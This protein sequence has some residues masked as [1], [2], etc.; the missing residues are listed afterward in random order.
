MRIAFVGTE[1]IPYPAAFATIAEELGVRL[2]AKGHQVLVY[3]RSRYIGDRSEYRGIERV[4]LPS[5]H[6]KYLDTISFTFLS[7]IDLLLRRKVDLVHIFG[8]GPALLSFMPRIRAIRTVVQVHGLDY[9]RKKWGPTAKFALRAGEKCSVMFP[10]ATL[11]IS[12]TLLDHYRSMSCDR[13]FYIPNGINPI[14][15]ER[16]KEIFRYG[17]DKDSYL[18]YLGRLTP[19]K[20]VDY[21]IQAFNE[22]DTGKKLVIAGGARFSDSYVARLR[23]MAGPDV[24]FVGAVSGRL[25]DELMTN[26]CFFVNPSEME[27]LCATILEAMSCGS[28]VLVSDIPENLEAIQRA[29][30]SF[31]SMD[32]GDLREKMKLLLTKPEVNRAYRE[33][34]QAYMN[35]ERLTWDGVT[36]EMETFYRAILSSRTPGSE[37]NRTEKI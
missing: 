20:G 13:V 6:N 17:L 4:P 21:L 14:K 16:P 36:E 7:L 3:C 25:R 31:R 24:L 30:L 32:P 15:K 2:V 26:C 9:R 18:L 34:A 28:T 27:G 1:G 35:R 12:R 29:G 8:I 37:L 19:E 33:K 5:I 11:V 22:L 10:H 23:E